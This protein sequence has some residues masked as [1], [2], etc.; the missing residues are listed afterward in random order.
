MT[1]NQTANELTL[2]LARLLVLLSNTGEANNQ[3]ATSSTGHVGPEAVNAQTNTEPRNLMYEAAQQQNQRFVTLENE[4]KHQKD[5]SVVLRRFASKT[6]EIMGIVNNLEATLTQQQTTITTLRTDL[7]KVRTDLKTVRTELVNTRTDLKTV[8]TDFDIYKDEST[9]EKE[10]LTNS[11]QQQQTTNTTLRTD[12]DIVRTDF[13]KY[14]GDST[15]KVDKNMNKTNNAFT[16]IMAILNDITKTFNTNFKNITV[17]IDKFKEE[18]KECVNQLEEVLDICFEIVPSA[19]VMHVNQAELN[20]T[21]AQ[22]YENYKKIYNIIEKLVQIEENVDTKLNKGSNIEGIKHSKKI[23]NDL[24]TTQDQLF[25][26]GRSSNTNGG[27]RSTNGG[28]RSTS[29]K[30]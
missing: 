6:N 18:Q 3:T 16:N 19:E 5:T 21:Q 20:E 8:R 13:D 29:T 1:T 12:L 26:T 27:S 7:D 25:N 17:R 9:R 14:K 22:L 2:Q 28:S 23:I 24:L 11:L 15:S 4:M 10:A 30:K